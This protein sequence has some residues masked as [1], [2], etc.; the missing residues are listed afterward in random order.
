M[1]AELRRAGGTVAKL[2]VVQRFSGRTAV[3]AELLDG[4]QVVPVPEDRVLAQ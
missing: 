1:Q 4:S 3:V 2:R